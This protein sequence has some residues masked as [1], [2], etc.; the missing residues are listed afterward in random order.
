MRRSG[1]ELT[2]PRR[3]LA[4]HD[5]KGDLLRGGGAVSVGAGAVFARDR[6]AKVLEQ[7][8]RF[9]PPARVT[10]EDATPGRGK[11]KRKD[12]WVGPGASCQK[13]CCG[14]ERVRGSV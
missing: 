12:P 9:Q 11:G 7:R 5:G 4:M 8:R 10:S 14:K 2:N 3:A 13:V 6:Y 1:T